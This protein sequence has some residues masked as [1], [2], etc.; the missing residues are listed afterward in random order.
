MPAYCSALSQ[1]GMKANEQRYENTTPTE[2]IPS[3]TDRGSFCWYFFGTSWFS[4]LNVI[5]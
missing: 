2:R 4:E 5:E 1:N 3:G